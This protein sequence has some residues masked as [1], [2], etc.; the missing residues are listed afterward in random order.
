MSVRRATCGDIEVLAAI[1]AA[2]FPAAEAWSRDVFD[3]QLALHNV[4][5]LV[6]DLGGMVLL[7][8]AAD[9]AEILTLAVVPDARRTGVGY[10]LLMQATEL[11]SQMGGRKLF[12]EVSVRNIAARGLYTKAGFTEAGKRRQYYSDGS[13]ALVLRCDLPAATSG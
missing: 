1:H 11:V 5:G 10:N 13:D 12:L 4:V 2:A 6:H 9:E 3:L 7:R 8:V